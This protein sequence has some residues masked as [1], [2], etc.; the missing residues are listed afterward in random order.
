M[1]GGWI[2]YACAVGY[3]VF[4]YIDIDAGSTDVQVDI[5]IESTT[6]DV[7]HT[8]YQHLHDIRIKEVPREKRSI[9]LFASATLAYKQ[10]QYP[11]TLCCRH[12]R[13]SERTPPSLLIAHSLPQS[14][15][16]SPTQEEVDKGKMTIVYK[17]R[18]FSCLSIR[19]SILP[20]GN[21]PI[22][23]GPVPACPPVGYLVHR[24]KG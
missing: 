4:L 11:A 22:F 24:M 9:T 1:E 5:Y 16:V 7:H 23:F 12:T 15:K 18:K 6:N 21:F 2:R 19:P 10:R 8:N 14:V 20:C 17:E 3:G 13:A